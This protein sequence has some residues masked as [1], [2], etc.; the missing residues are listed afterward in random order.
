MDTNKGYAVVT[1][2]SSGIGEAYAVQLAQRGYDL[3]L[4][5]RRLKRL[6]HLADRIRTTSGRFVSTIEA[7]LAT[8]HGSSTIERL[9]SED[10]SVTLLVNNAGL[11]GLGTMEEVEIAS[12]DAVVRVNVL[13]VTRLS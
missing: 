4:V 10:N 1:G 12:L 7:D 2:A 11:G 6:E 5:A 9:L 3:I 13:A 8:E